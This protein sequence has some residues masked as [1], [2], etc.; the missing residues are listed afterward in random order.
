MA[1][2]RR[3]LV[4]EQR[5]GALDL[6][7]IDQRLRIELALRLVGE[8]ERVL[9]DH[10]GS[11]GLGVALL[12]NRTVAAPV[13]EISEP[14]HVLGVRLPGGRRRSLVEL[15]RPE[16][17]RRAVAIDERE[18]VATRLGDGER[19]GRTLDG[20]GCL[21]RR[22]AADAELRSMRPRRWARGRGSRS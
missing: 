4:E 19:L 6:L 16:A 10:V 7:R 18:H 9:E 2:V 3:H 21:P 8:A 13:T 14:H 12:G 11:A 15:D 17:L 1:V 22:G 20:I 5:L